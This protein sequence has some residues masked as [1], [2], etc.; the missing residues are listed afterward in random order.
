MKSSASYGIVYSS[1]PCAEQEG[2]ANFPLPISEGKD[3]TK[4]SNPCADA[5]IDANWGLLLLLRIIVNVR[6]PLT[7]TRSICGHDICMH[8]AQNNHSSSEA[9]VK[10]TDECTKN[11]Q[12]FWNIL[13]KLSLLTKSSATTVHTDN[14]GCVDWCNSYILKNMHHINI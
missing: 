6:F 3:S 11:V 14:K 4:R 8:S 7:E 2:L 12:F 10:V 5:F 1:P 9:E 13:T